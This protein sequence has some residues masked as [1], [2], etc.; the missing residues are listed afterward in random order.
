[1]PWRSQS[2][3]R[4]GAAEGLERRQKRPDELEDAGHEDGSSQCLLKGPDVDHLRV[5]FFSCPRDETGSATL[6]ET[7]RVFLEKKLKSHP[8]RDQTA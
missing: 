1:M 2:R 4:A 6:R 3:R 5:C 8:A 7:A